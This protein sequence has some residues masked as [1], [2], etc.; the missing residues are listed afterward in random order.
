MGSSFLD[1]LETAEAKRRINEWLEREGKGEATVS[2]KLRDW[3]FSRQRY[4]GEPFPVLHLEDGTT[5]LVPHDE[6]PVLLPELDDWA[7]S[8]DFET[9][10]S[11]VP[12]WIATSDPETGKPARRDPNTMPQWAGSCWYFL[13][14]CDPHNPDTAWSEEAERY[15]M[16]VDLY[17]GGAE[18]AVLHLL[19]ARF[20]HKVLFDLGHV[21]T[22]EPFGKLF[23]QGM[24]R[25]FAYKDGRGSY[26]GY[27]E[28]DFHEDGAYRK[29]DGEK[30][31]GAVE[32]MSKSLK[33]V[34]NPDEVVSEYG[35]DSLRLYEMF[36]GPLDASKPWNPR[37]VP[38]VFRFLQRVWR[39]IAGEGEGL[40]S[41]VVDSETTASRAGPGAVLE[42][43]LHATIKKVGTDIDRMAF[44]TAISAMMSFV[45]EAYRVG[46]IHRDQAQRFVL[47]LAPFAPHISEELWQRLAGKAWDDSLAYEPWPTHDDG[48]LVEEEIEIPVQVNGKLA[49]R[50]TVAKD[51]GEEAVRTSAQ[52]NAKVAAR[53]GDAAVIKTIYVPGRMMNLIV[54][55]AP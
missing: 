55:K 6:L 45:N 49:G 24:I 5:K 3:L 36:M 25:A 26:V 8:G 29:A 2:Y 1:G 15:W 46:E 53:L 21:S 43:A 20:W 12:D 17:V 22:P 54:R 19:Y 37:D 13:R 9:P 38:G 50:I 18:H 35:A 23:N 28:I 41:M 42:K 7:P 4:W 48:L 33:N 34:I 11:R 39:L 30:L 51:A 16:P 40:S 14:F 44:N 31:S 52:A 32:K 10:L 27:E 47:L